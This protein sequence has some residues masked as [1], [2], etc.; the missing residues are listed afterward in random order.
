MRKKVKEVE[1]IE[2][3]PPID[4]VQ[5]CKLKQSLED[6]LGVFICGEFAVSAFEGLEPN[7]TA[8]L[9]GKIPPLP[10]GG[11]GL[12]Q[13]EKTSLGSGSWWVVRQCQPGLIES[14]QGKG[15]TI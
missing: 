6:F 14:E 4:K 1:I 15:Q 3:K 12:E 10:G 13:T 5:Y 8:L 2:H 7:S 9:H 11:T